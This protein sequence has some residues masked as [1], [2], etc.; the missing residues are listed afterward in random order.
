MGL[1]F[2]KL[3][4]SLITDKSEAY[5]VRL[6]V[7]GRLCGEIH[8]G[9]AASRSRLVLG[10]GGGSFPHVSASRYRTHEG[11]VGPESW[12]GFARVHADA[13][14]L[15]TMVCEHLRSAGVDAMPIQPSAVAQARGGEIVRW[16]TKPIERLLDGG[17]VPVPYGDAVTDELQG[18]A[19][20]STEELFRFLAPR[21][22]PRRILLVGKVDGVLD[23]DGRLIARITAADLPGIRSAL[24]GSDGVADV[25]GG[26]LQKVE[27]ALRMGAPVEIVNGLRPGLVRRALQGETGLG[28]EILPSPVV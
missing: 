7:L 24:G 21:L 3:G 17:L 13:A 18:C 25:T 9:L 8:E 1:I 11:I 12:A 2:L 10:H 4:G 27:H 23:G 6:D 15:N 19:I 28:T 22:E 20:A 5:T 14:R 16:D 26:M